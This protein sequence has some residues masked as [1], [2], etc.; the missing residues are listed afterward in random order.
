MLN[1]LSS[2][3]IELRY[4]PIVSANQYQNLLYSSLYKYD[5]VYAPVLHD[6]LSKLTFDL[7]STSNLLVLH[8]HW[9]NNIYNGTLTFASAYKAINNHFG[10]IKLFSIHGG[11]VIW[12]VHN[13]YDHDIDDP[14]V[15]LL[16]QYCISQMAR[17]A[18][19]ILI[20]SQDTQPA[21][22]EICGFKVSDRVQVL[23]HPLYD[24]MLSIQP[25]CPAELDGLPEFNGLTYLCFGLLRPYKGGF[26]LL[27][28]YHEQL[29]SGRLENTRLILA[30]IIQD[31]S[32]LREHAGLPDSIRSRIILINRRVSD[33]ELAWLCIHCDIAV[34]PYREIL[35]SG[36][37]YQATTFALPTIVPY[38]GMFKSMV[39]D[40]EDALVYR[41]DSEL[42]ATLQRAHTIGKPSLRRMGEKALARQQPL[43]AS[44]HVSEQFAQLLRNLVESPS[45][46]TPFGDP[47]KSLNLTAALLPNEATELSPTLELT[48]NLSALNFFEKLCWWC[49]VHHL[50][51]ELGRP[52]VLI[53]IEADLDA[54]LINEMNRIALDSNYSLRWHD[55][56]HE[57]SSDAI[58][59]VFASSSMSLSDKLLRRFGRVDIYPAAL[60]SVWATDVYWRLSSGAD[61][62]AAFN[63]LLASVSGE[64]WRD[65]IGNW[66]DSVRP[67]DFQVTAL[68]S[69]FNGD[70]FL[71]GFLDNA[72]HWDSYPACEHLL[73][74]AAS[75][76]NEHAA[77]MRHVQQHPNAVYIHLDHDPGLYAVWNL[78]IRIA[79]GKFVTNANLDD[80]RAPEQLSNLVC[81]LDTHSD[82]S[83]VSAQIRFSTQP[84]L[85][86]EDSTQCDILFR[87]QP[88]CTYGADKLFF[89]DERGVGSYNLPHC[90]PVW[91]RSL[92]SK[93]GYFDERRSGASADWA[94]WIHAGLQDARYTYIASPMGLYLRHAESYWRRSSPKDNDQRIA[95]EYASRA[96]RGLHQSRSDYSLR[97]R[98]DEA[99]AAYSEDDS[100]GLLSGLLDCAL[101]LRHL[102]LVDSDNS[103]SRKLIDLMASH[104]L[105]MPEF[106]AFIEQHPETLNDMSDP[107]NNVLDFVVEL[108]HENLLPTDSSASIFR[109]HL[110]CALL[111]HYLL[112]RSIKPLLIL[113]FL[114]RQQNCVDAEE[115]LLVRIRELA[116]QSFLAEKESVYRSET[117]RISAAS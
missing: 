111:D 9:L 15:R 54:C 63:S 22:E 65:E 33:A 87:N 67:A 44:A 96:M 90:M 17:V 20:H 16:N 1:C 77:L 14:N 116:A 56:L 48:L 28:H 112:T 82:I 3:S 51:K 43:S 101:R 73:I 10:H 42:G 104:W 79:S 81:Y 107:L 12:T 62:R 106:V 47:N 89:H 35:T 102:D 29:L 5:V 97:Q 78:G 41:E 71:A 69:I 64:G 50:V 95:A 26:E 31:K 8:Q 115:Y 114:K 19:L 2:S 91:R 39:T 113:A 59:R 36:S 57:T 80:R 84:N 94:F 110:E 74:R 13:L 46:S 75:P 49:W 85:T 38:S 34:L 100:L 83:A 30:G 105:G 37:Y 25:V 66:I 109:R 72:A 60:P 61:W 103:A 45:P 11:K 6:Q 68:T 52:T 108:L 93:A 76:G 55:P 23:P 88:T 40:G 92:H 27:L 32:L 117:P 53:L 99:L 98:I 21:L 7:R 18:D 58:D 4:L 70:S 24:S 86:W